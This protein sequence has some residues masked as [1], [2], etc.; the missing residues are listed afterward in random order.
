MLLGFLPAL[1]P[2]EQL[3]KRDPEL[4]GER[5]EY[6]HRRI[7]GTPFQAPHHISMNTREAGQ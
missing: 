4:H 7:I 1:R 5:R 2:P 3:L 6:Q